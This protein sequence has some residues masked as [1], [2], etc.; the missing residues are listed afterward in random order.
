[1]TDPNDILMAADVAGILGVQA[2][3]VRKL[4]YDRKL[5]YHRRSAG[6]HYLFL[7]SDVEE[8]KKERKKKPPR[9]GRPKTPPGQQKLPMKRIEKAAKV[10][11]KIETETKE[12]AKT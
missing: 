10:T 9:V 5:K 4:V 7:R 2:V 11:K 12:S 3:T 6:G 8:L 1:M